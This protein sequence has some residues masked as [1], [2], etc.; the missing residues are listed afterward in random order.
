[1]YLLDTNICIAFLKNHR[2]V[3]KYVSQHIAR[4]YLAAVVVA[5]LYKGV[6]CSQQVQQN[7]QTLDEFLTLLPILNFDQ[8]AAL[9]FGQIQGELKQMG[10]PTGELDAMIAAVAR[11]QDFILVTD[12]IKHFQNIQNLQLENWLL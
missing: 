5:E 4:C 3:V 10:R 8:A 11:S 9:E 1:M 12:N 2:N 6:Y 7:R